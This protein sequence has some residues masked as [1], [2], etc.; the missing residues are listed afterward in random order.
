MASLGIRRLIK[1]SRP[2][3]W[4]YLLGPFLL[5]I[6]AGTHRGDLRMLAFAWPVLLLFLYH[7]TFASNL[8]LYGVNDIFDYE[9]DKLNPKKQSYEALVSPVER[10]A[11]VYWILIAQAPMIVYLSIRLETLLAV[12]LCIALFI[13]LSISYS[14]PPIRAKARPFLDSLFNI[15]YVIPGLIG[16]LFVSTPERIQWSLILAG[17][18]WCMAMHAYSAVPD[19]EADTNAGL[20]TIATSLGK[21]RTLWLCIACYS[22]ATLLAASVIDWLAYLLGAV[23]LTLMGLSLI[24]KTSAELFRYY[25]LFP[26]INALSG[27][28]L[29]FFILLTK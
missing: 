21:I 20:H 28:A 24:T 19:I 23:Y 1:I 4:I 25:K 13:L 8:L 14:A 16:F 9:T 29:F 11:L 15:L 18:L 6:I 2:R 12:S 17:C 3:F 5:G 27:A 10:S 26:W 22:A 7:F